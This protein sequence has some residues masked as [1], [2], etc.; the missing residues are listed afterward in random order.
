MADTKR[1]ETD[2]EAQNRLVKQLQENAAKLRKA[3][4]ENN[5]A[6]I[7]KYW[8]EATRIEKE[9]RSVGTLGTVGSAIMSGV[10]GLL[11]GIPD[12][13]TAGLNAVGATKQPIKSLGQRVSEFSGFS[14]EPMSN[15]AAPL[16]RV[17][18]GASSG[19]VG[20]GK[21]AVI[22]GLLGGADVA[23]SS[24]T[25]GAIPEGAM[26]AAYA[27]GAISKSIYQ[28]LKNLAK[29]RKM[30]QFIND[31]PTR[32]SNAFGQFMLKGQGSDDPL[33]NA[34]IQ[35]LR[36]NPKYAELLA[37]LEEGAT[38]EATMNMAPTGRAL[39]SEQEA[40]AGIV[41]RIQAEFKGL[42]D[43]VKD[44]GT[45][46]FEVAKQYGGD[47]GVVD[48]TLTLERIRSLKAEY[49]KKST[50]NA[51][52]A[53]EA[54]TSIEDN[55]T[56]GIVPKSTGVLGEP[57]VPEK[58]P[59]MTVEK[60]QALL[61]EFGKKAA[62][63]DS[64][65]KDLAI[66]DEQRISAAIF[67][68]LK[69]DLKAA[70]LAAVTPEDKAATGVLL[71]ARQQVEKAATAYQEKVAQGLPNYLQNKSLSEV[72]Y[73]D[74]YNQYKKLSPTNRAV[75]REYVGKTDQEALNFIDKNVYQDFI[76]SARGTNMSGLQGTNLE[77]LANNWFSL[78]KNEKD[79]L[80]TALGTNAAEFEQRMKD[81]Q[82][83]NRKMQVNIKAE[84]PTVS[85]D[86]QRSTSALAG[87]VGGYPVAK[88][89]E[90]S[91]DALNV[92][93]KTGLND[94]QLARALLTPEGAQFLR[95]A[96]LTKSGKKTLD[97]LTKF[98]SS[99]PSPEA[100]SAISRLVPNKQP[101]QATEAP[102]EAPSGFVMPPNLLESLD[103]NVAPSEGTSSG[104][105]IPPNLMEGLRSQG[106]EKAAQAI[107]SMD[108]NGP[109]TMNADAV[110][111]IKAAL[112]SGELQGQQAA[113]A[114][115]LL[116]KLG[117]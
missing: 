98:T 12:I 114:Q 86:L 16:Y 63:G 80:T 94:E 20:G 72:E 81:A 10:S 43:K 107:S 5:K 41:T 8:D 67:G 59:K 66:S 90:L 75:M 70:R 39:A 58:I 69:D 24:A 113:E 102:T 1:P 95:S 40:T 48:P 22:G 55:L 105:V 21:G 6:D 89:T 23:A 77:K 25:N 2:V 44:A 97:E 51:Q 9:L 82:I 92:L 104:F 101:Q 7:K 110:N 112:Q 47:R 35:K 28:G 29:D 31:L 45:S 53:V 108:V 34:A 93:K 109:A 57:V 117:Y 18:Q 13:V 99:Q 4:A 32:E 19:I 52:K 56:Q 49:A 78:P 85:N 60:V 38:K 15:E 50:P 91:I 111:G 61:S 96:A 87:A 73:A 42:K 30:Q 115:A 62:T 71:Q 64:L 37:K 74:L 84:S 83:F 54:L 116:A 33:V 79:A 65:I 3:T 46:A 36:T 14:Q 76:D 27:T 88:G 17:L 26:S 103:N 106:E 100:I 68:G 11:T